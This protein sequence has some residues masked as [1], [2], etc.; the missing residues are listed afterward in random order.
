MRGTGCVEY[1]NRPK[2]SRPVL[3]PEG[4]AAFEGMLE[5]M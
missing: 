5:R 1:E 2:V 3:V 4:S